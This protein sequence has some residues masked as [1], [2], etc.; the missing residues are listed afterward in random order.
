MPVSWQ[1][2]FY[3]LR[4]VAIRRGQAWFLWSRGE[5]LLNE[6]FPDFDDDLRSL[7]PGTVL[8]GELVGWKDGQVLPFGELQKRI[9]RKRIGP[10]ILRDVP[11]KFIAFDVLEH[12]GQDIR[13]TPMR[14]RRDTL[15]RLLVN[16]D[17]DSRLM[18]SPAI[19]AEQR[20]SCVD[21]IGLAFV[22]RLREFP[23]VPSL[24]RV[25]I[26][27]CAHADNLR[28]IELIKVCPELLEWREHDHIRVE[29]EDAACRWKVIREEM[30]GG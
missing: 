12:Q 2:F 23:E 6:R 28:L 25:H 9:A 22:F 26:D 18:I 14:Q 15:E 3:T 10:K 17:E 27:L 5:E 4:S 16:R 24:S 13:D 19:E 11:V 21:A 30:A 7:P 8:D 1:K 29:V 20:K